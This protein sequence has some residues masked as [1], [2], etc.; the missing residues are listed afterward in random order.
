[1]LRIVIITALALF[2]ASCAA[3]VE[4]SVDDVG[5]TP[6]LDAI[7]EAAVSEGFPGLTLA[8]TDVEGAIRAGAAGF[9]DRRTGGEMAPESRIHAASV[10]KSITAVATLK[11]VDR[12]VIHLDATLPSLVSESVVDGLPNA[13]AITLRHLLEHTSGLYSPN[14]DPVYLARYIGPHRLVMLFWAAEEIVAFA[15]NDANPPAFAPGA[16]SKYSD[17]NYVLLSL[18]VAQASG[19][20]FKD[21]V[22]REVFDAAGMT[23]S[24]FLSDAPDAPRARGYTLDS[25]VLRTIGLDPA[26]TADADGLIDTT[27]AQEQSDGAAGVISTAPDLARF[28]HAAFHGGL[29]LGEESRAFLLDVARRAAGREGEEALGALRGYDKSYGSV[30]AAEGD[31]PGT[32]VVWVMHVES[33]RIVAAATNLFGRW[34]ENDYLMDVVV[35]AALAIE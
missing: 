7:A 30:V 24:Y 20:T 19:E 35:P 31:G 2:A 15:K 4:R 23:D 33:G 6:A 1:M 8:V 34:D 27:D 17:V 16:G 18:V 5:R 25:E 28:A 14:N 13:D 22:R 9:A 26:L 12:S 32:N 3:T 21:F 29:L 10:T 11:L